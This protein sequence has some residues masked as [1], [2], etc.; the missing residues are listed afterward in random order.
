MAIS[1]DAH[2]CYYNDIA[3]KTRQRFD[4]NK[5]EYIAFGIEQGVSTPITIYLT[6]EQLEQLAFHVTTFL[7]DLDYQ[8]E[9]T[10]EEAI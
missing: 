4:S 1:I 9:Q 7:Q 3:F 2:F 6:R 10:K 5:K 8:G